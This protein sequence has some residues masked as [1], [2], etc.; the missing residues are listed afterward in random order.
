MEGVA[1]LLLLLLVLLL[2]PVSGTSFKKQGLLCKL[3]YLHVH[4]N[5]FTWAKDYPVL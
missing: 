4:L 3:M 5:A 2:L 1:V